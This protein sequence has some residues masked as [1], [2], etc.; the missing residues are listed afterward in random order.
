MNKLKIMFVTIVLLSALSSCGNNSE[1]S[2]SNSE[3]SQKE[4]EVLT[5]SE[6][7]DDAIQTYVETQMN[8]EE[9]VYPVLTDEQARELDTSWECDY[10]KISKCSNWRE[11]LSKDIDDTSS[12]FC[13][14]E[15]FDGEEKHSITFM[16]SD[17]FAGIIEKKSEKELREWFEY[18]KEDVE[19]L[20]LVDTF[21]ENNQA[22]MITTT[23]SYEDSYEL[24]FYTDKVNGSISFD[25]ED[26]DIVREMIDSIV[27]Y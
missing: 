11:Y 5:D 27:Y 4:S 25:K 3:T 9:K 26:E 2:S 7:S 13:N 23:T 21:V 10:L 24:Q 15:W 19:D 14:W 22:Y 17:E 20:V 1:V 6:E 18:S 8:G 12:Y 16:I